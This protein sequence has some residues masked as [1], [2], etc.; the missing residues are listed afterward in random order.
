[1]GP[2]RSSGKKKEN[3]EGIAIERKWGTRERGMDGS[4][5]GREVIK[6]SIFAAKG[7]YEEG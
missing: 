5:D 7:V 2:R 6:R 4:K 3:F 1:L